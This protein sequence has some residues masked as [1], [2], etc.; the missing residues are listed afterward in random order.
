L[1]VA[2]ATALAFP[3][4]VPAAGGASA[5]ISFSR[6]TMML[7][8]AIGGVRAVVAGAAFFVG[9]LD[10]VTAVAIVTVSLLIAVAG[11][12]AASL[13]RDRPFGRQRSLL[14]GAALLV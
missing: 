1:P 13:Q 11:F 14:A 8:G 6:L 5:R 3:A 7:A 12:G 2:A 10:P 9:I 4:A